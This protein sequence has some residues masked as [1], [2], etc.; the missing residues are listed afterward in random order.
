MQT[1]HVEDNNRPVC[2]IRPRPEGICTSPEQVVEQYA[3]R[4][5]DWPKPLATFD[6]V[7]IFVRTI[8]VREHVLDVDL[9]HFSPLRVGHTAAL[10][11]L[12]G[13]TL[14]NLLVPNHYIAQAGRDE[15]EPYGH[16]IV[17][18][19]AWLPWA[20]PPTLTGLVM[21]RLYDVPDVPADEVLAAVI[22]CSVG[23]EG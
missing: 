6:T 11:I 9:L 10:R 14:S 5:H 19:D 15:G 21:A 7:E 17:Q 18:H 8:K 20:S 3:W 4:R 23:A 13:Q 12:Q 2:S 22:A 16:L 1:F